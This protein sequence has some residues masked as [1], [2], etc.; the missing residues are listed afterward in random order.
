MVFSISDNPLFERVTCMEILVALFYLIII[1]IKQKYTHSCG[2]WKS[3]I[4][5]P[6]C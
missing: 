4:R 5:E 6:E 2:G 1:I 3:E